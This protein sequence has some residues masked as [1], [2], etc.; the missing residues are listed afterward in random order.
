M[1]E[2]SWVSIVIFQD[3]KV[4]L[5]QRIKVRHVEPKESNI[6]AAIRELLKKLDLKLQLLAYS[7]LEFPVSAYH[8]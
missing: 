2:S 6:N 3:N 4:L 8:V 1:S 7:K 5:G